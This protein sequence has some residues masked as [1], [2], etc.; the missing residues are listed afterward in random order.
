MFSG[1]YEHSVD[2]K[3]RTVIPARFRQKLG[4]KFVMTRGLHGC[5]WIFPER[6]WSTVQQ[7]LT[8]KSLLDDR[9]IKLERYFLGAACECAPDRQGRVAIPSM[10][11]SH[12]GI[13][14]GE[15]VWVVGLTDKVEVWSRAKWDE[16]NASL[17]DEVIAGLGREA[18]M[19][20]Y[21]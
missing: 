2:D 19:P 14:S 6:T 7:K 3:G 16:F 10:L 15:S 18:E 20:Q 17:T 4:E 5:L 9:G 8:P 12:A 21:G 1:A 11:M 13:K